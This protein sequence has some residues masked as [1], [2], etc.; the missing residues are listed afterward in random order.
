MTPGPYDEVRRYA[1]V[2]SGIIPK[3][4]AA[5]DG[6]ARGKPG[7]DVVAGVGKLPEDRES[8]RADAGARVRSCRFRTE[9]AVRDV[10]GDGGRDMYVGAREP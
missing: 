6:D 7:G 9:V 1:R 10:Q 5:A 3:S 2:E 8:H 4:R